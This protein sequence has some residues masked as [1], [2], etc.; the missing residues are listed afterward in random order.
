MGILLLIGIIV[1][2]VADNADLFGTAAQLEQI[3]EAVLSD[4]ELATESELA[5]LSQDERVRLMLIYVGVGLLARGIVLLTPL[6][7]LNILMGY[8]AYRATRWWVVV[9]A[10]IWGMIS[11]NLSR[12][13]ELFIQPPDYHWTTIVVAP[14]TEEAF[15]SIAIIVMYLFFLVRYTGDGLIYGFAVGSGFAI[16]ENTLYIFNA[17]SIGAEMTIALSRVITTGMVHGGIAAVVGVFV[18]FAAYYPFMRAMRTGLTWFVGAM[19]VHSAY[20]LSHWLTTGRLDMLISVIIGISMVG[21]LVWLLQANIRRE[22]NEFYDHLHDHLN[23]VELALA[24]HG[25]ELWN[26]LL[27]ARSTLGNKQAK[28]IER[29]L[30]LEGRIALLTDQQQDIAEREFAKRILQREIGGL[31]KRLSRISKKMTPESQQ[32][33]NTVTAELAH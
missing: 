27:A 32:W 6:F 3:S 20:N 1:L 2:I 22:T 21:I 19:G 17:N 23:D 29:Y 11:F 24:R 28:L 10:L 12:Q 9:M 31:Q 18:S 15:K 30:T 7:F 16:A 8:E 4:D 14:I 5:D 25:E 13:V 33:L 26:R